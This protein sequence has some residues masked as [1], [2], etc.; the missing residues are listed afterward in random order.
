M[1]TNLKRSGKMQDLNHK[2]TEVKTAWDSVAFWME[3]VH[4]WTA[5]TASWGD[6]DGFYARQ[7]EA[8]WRM[9]EMDLFA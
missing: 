7:V 2:V 3:S 6:D 1:A 8:A 9:V 4:Y 5:Q